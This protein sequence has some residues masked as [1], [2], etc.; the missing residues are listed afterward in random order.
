MIATAVTAAFAV[1]LILVFPIT[2]IVV[3]V[4]TV[5]TII[6]PLVTMVFPVTRRVITGVPVIM[7]KV[8][9]LGARIVFMAMPSPIPDV[10]RWYTQID[11]WS[12]RCTLNEYRSAIDHLWR[13]IAANVDMP[14]ETRLAN[15]D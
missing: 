14:I 10:A 12:L 1:A 2:A 4:I 11:R 7:H 6:M 9:P 15:A 8:D 3:F 13:R 5:V